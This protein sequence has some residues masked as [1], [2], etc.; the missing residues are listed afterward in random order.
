MSQL[1][2]SWLMSIEILCMVGRRG[3]GAKKAGGQ[4]NFVKFRI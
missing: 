2:S 1:H 3:A 4:T